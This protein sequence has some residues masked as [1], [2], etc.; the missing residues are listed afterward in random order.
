[1]QSYLTQSS[2]E[3]R[4]GFTPKD[5]AAGGLSI[6]DAKFD[7]ADCKSVGVDVNECLKGGYTATEIKAGERLR[8]RSQNYAY[9]HRYANLT[10]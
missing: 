2:C 4:V 7:C 6:K 5:F 8:G 10:R 3:R 9:Y 1:M